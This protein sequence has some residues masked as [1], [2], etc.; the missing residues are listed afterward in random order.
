MLGKLWPKIKTLHTFLTRTL[1]IKSRENAKKPVFPA[2]FRHFRPKKNFFR[3][4][5]SVTFR[6]LSFCVSVQNFMK[7]IKYSLRY[8]RNTVFPAKIAVPAIFRQFWLQKSVF[9]TIETCLMVGLS[10]IHISEPTRP[11]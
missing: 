11:Y 2:Y 4:S 5:D 7:N 10:L 8:S 9:L 6:T 3:K 1:M